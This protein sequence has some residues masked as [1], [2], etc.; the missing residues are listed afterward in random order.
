MLRISLQRFAQHDNYRSGDRRTLFARDVRLGQGRG[1][2]Y[3]GY[4]AV[5][6]PGGFQFYSFDRIGLGAERKDPGD[7]AINVEVVPALTEVLFLHDRCR[8]PAVG[9]LLGRE[10]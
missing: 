8:F 10:R 4:F 7:F 5:G 9:Q 6:L 2:F 1:D 3:L